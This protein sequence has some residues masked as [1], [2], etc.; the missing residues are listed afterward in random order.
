M[1]RELIGGDLMDH[2]RALPPAQ[3]AIALVGARQELIDAE[4]EFRR[5][6]NDASLAGASTTGPLQALA[7]AAR[8]GQR[9]IQ[10][11]LPAA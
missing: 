1:Y 10:A 5:A 3:R 2:A 6:A 9:N 8:D 4:S 11:L 7:D